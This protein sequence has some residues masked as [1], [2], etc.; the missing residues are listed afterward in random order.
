MY[1][2]DGK[3]PGPT[4]PTFGRPIPPA[5]APMIVPSPGPSSAP[6]SPVARLGGPHTA[7][8]RPGS[9]KVAE[10]RDLGSLKDIPPE[11]QGVSVKD[12]VKAL[13][14]YYTAYYIFDAVFIVQF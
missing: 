14:E 1:F 9:P 11:L 8:P 5:S 10:K 12:L 13:G 7:A 3:S 2:S 4:W 6:R